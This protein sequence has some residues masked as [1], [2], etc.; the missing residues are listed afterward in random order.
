MNILSSFTHPMS[1]QTCVCFFLTL[2]IKEF[3]RMVIK[4]LMISIDFTFTL[5]FSHLA[6]AFIQSDLQI[7]KSYWNYKLKV[8][9]YYIYTLKK[10]KN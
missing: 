6:D 2:N 8:Y 7:R 9:K 10:I 1:F 5:L 4:P 3:W